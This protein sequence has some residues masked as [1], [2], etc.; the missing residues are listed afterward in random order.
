MPT[1]TTSFTEKSATNPL[2]VVESIAEVNEWMFDRRSDQEMAVQAPGTWCDYSLFF[3]WND[4]IEAMHF[5]CAFDMRVPPARRGPLYELL[6]VVNEKLWL[7]HFGFWED[8]GLPLF[9]HAV[10]MRGADGLSLG[11]MEDLVDNALFECE[12]FYPAFQYVLWGGKSAADAVS[13]AMVETVGE[14]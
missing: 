8:K 13:A 5:T 2:D 10:P 6:A 4:D 7:G 12:R 11:Q 9:R 3:A 1:V 14:A